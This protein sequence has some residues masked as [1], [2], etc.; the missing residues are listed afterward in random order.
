MDTFHCSNFL[1][2]DY[3]NSSSNVC[4]CLILFLIS[5]LSGVSHPARV[6]KVSGQ[7]RV[8]APPEDILLKT[9]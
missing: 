4:F 2:N 9:L 3:C 8:T 1:V 5:H 6:A 7:A